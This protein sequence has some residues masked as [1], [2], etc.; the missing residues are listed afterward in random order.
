LQEAFVKVIMGPEKKSRVISE[1]DR[2]ITAYHEAGH[3]VVTK[4]MPTRD[5]VHQVSIIPRGRAGG[6]T[7]HLPTEDKSHYTKSDMLE[8]IVVF[9]GGRVAE[10][11]ILDDIST[12]ASN[13]IERATD[14]VRSMITK[15]G[16]SDRLGPIAY[17][18]QNDEVFLGKDYTHMRNYSES[19]AA[20]IDEEV[21]R[22]MKA[23]YQ[24]CE[25]ILR[26]HIDSLHAVAGYLLKHESMDG[27]VF[28]RIM[29]GEDIA[30]IEA[31]E[32]EKT[33]RRAEEEARRREESERRMM[34]EDAR[35]RAEREA[36]Q[37]ETR[38]APLPPWM[39]N[40]IDHDVDEKK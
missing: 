11:I 5:P 21:Q 6:Y 27:E 17:G 22:Y 12:G 2:R 35:R 34:E 14:I 25:Q 15:Y 13:D 8:E 23:A 28:N 40:H 36:E 39:Q 24:K 31:D 7:L 29:N 18:S 1:K 33:R 9:L 10:H 20:Q 4:F 26:E 30:A 3:A 16:M 19:V 37:S 38:S 32:E